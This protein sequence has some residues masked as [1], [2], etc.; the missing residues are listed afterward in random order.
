MWTDFPC[1]LWAGAT[2]LKDRQ[3]YG[4]RMVAGQKVLVHREALENRLG[5][6]LGPGMKA[7]HHC[8]VMKCYEPEHLYEG[9]QVQ[10]MRDRSQRGRARNQRR[11]APGPAEQAE[12]RKQY[13]AGVSK[14]ELSKR[15][16]VSR[17]SIR[18]IVGEWDGRRSGLR[19]VPAA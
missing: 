9:T 2:T 7:L 12:I 8:D 10:N 3:G 11:P 17:G 14:L 6:P 19:Q 13:A 4:V 1:L 5:R 16:Q 15:F 18:I